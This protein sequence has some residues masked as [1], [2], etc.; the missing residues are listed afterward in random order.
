[1][2]NAPTIAL[3]SQI[4]E[5]LMSA[6]SIQFELATDTSVPIRAGLLKCPRAPSLFPR[7]RE[8]ISRRKRKLGGIQRTHE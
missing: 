7:D 4:I 3:V 2:A 6:W 8:R 1:V 5:A